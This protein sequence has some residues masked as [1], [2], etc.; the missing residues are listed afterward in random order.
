[1]NVQDAGLYYWDPVRYAFI[2]LGVLSWLRAYDTGMGSQLYHIANSSL[3]ATYVYCLNGGH[4]WD[5]DRV[6][7][8]LGSFLTHP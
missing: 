2:L 6:V 3:D 4:D 1:M 5:R 8:K 7:L